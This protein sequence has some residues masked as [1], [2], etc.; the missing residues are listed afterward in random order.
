MMDAQILVNECANKR[1]LAIN[2]LDMLREDRMRYVDELLGVL[3]SAAQ[4]P[5]NQL[6]LRLHGYVEKARKA[7]LEAY[8]AY[9]TLVRAT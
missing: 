2:L 1:E 8:V 5:T 3:N 4:L 6:L 7:E 9:V